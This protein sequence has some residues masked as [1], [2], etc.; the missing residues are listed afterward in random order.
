[1]SA[2]VARCVLFVDRGAREQSCTLAQPVLYPENFSPRLNRPDTVGEICRNTSPVCVCVVYTCLHV[3]MAIVQHSHHGV[4]ND[5]DS[6]S[7]R[8]PTV[9]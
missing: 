6:L 9:P 1:M 7:M 3:D 8:L 5:H 4:L 2:H